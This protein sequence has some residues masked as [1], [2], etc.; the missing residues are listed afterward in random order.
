MRKF[1]FT[2]IRELLP[3]NA[4]MHLREFYRKIFKVYGG[5]TKNYQKYNWN[6]EPVV[7]F[8]NYKLTYLMEKIMGERLVSSGLALTLW[9]MKGDGFPLHIDSVPPFDITLDIVVDHRGIERRPIHLLRKTDSLWENGV[10]GFAV[11]SVESLEQGDAVLFKGSEMPHFGG[12][13]LNDQS[14]HNVVLWT[15]NYIRD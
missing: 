11:N 2:V 14:Y 4:L 9:I 8:Y 12:D 13:L 3:F 7:R 10:K 15:W 1:G 5:H 6:D